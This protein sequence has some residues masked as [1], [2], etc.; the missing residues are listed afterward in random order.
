MLTVVVL[1]CLELL[2]LGKFLLCNGCDCRIMYLL[3]TGHISIG[4]GRGDNLSSNVNVN[5]G[6]VRNVMLF[7]E[8]RYLS[9]INTSIAKQFTRL[10]GTI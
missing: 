8:L 3:E 7:Q 2:V 5:I 6:Y 9:D 10:H 4:S 1:I